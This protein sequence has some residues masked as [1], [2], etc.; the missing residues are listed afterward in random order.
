M[1]EK[2]QNSHCLSSVALVLQN[3]FHNIYRARN[4]THKRSIFCRQV[5]VCLSVCLSVR[6]YDPV[7]YQNGL[8][9]RP[10]SSTV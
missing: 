4:A 8:T 3:Y 5:S 2:L 7:L 9:Y 10:N 6:N 1:E